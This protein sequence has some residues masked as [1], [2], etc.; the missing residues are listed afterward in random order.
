MKQVKQ[1]VKVLVFCAIVFGIC[2]I[3]NGILNTNVRSYDSTANP[4]ADGSKVIFLGTS[5]AAN[6]INPL[7]MWDEQGIAG[8]NFS[9][10][11]QYIGT[12]YY[13]LKDLYRYQTPEVIM[14]DF[15]CMTRPEDFLTI[16]NKLYNLPMIAGWKNRLDMYRDVIGDSP[17]YIIPMLRYH[18]RWKELSRLDFRQDYNVLG[19][20]RRLDTQ[21]ITEEMPGNWTIDRQVKLGERELAYLNRIYEMTEEHG[22]RLT[23][24][25]MP[26]YSSDEMESLTEQVRDWAKERG[27]AICEAN[28]EDAF[29]DMELMPE[30]FADLLHLNVSGQVKLSSYIGRWL[31]TECGLLDERDTE[32]GKLWEAKMP[33]YR[34]IFN[35]S[36]L[37]TTEDMEEYFELL[38][39]GNYTIAISLVGNYKSQDRDGRLWS[40]LRQFG[41]S[42]EAYDAGGGFVRDA[43]GNWIFTSGGASSFL[44]STVL[45][46]D[47]LVLRGSPSV[48]ADGN[49]TVRTEL[50]IYRSDQS[51][52]PNG[53]NVMVYNHEIDGVV[54]TVGFNADDEFRILRKTGE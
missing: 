44:W 46:E 11:G 3:A 12:T 2:L 6:G 21:E 43:Q 30:D 23:L 34:N 47:D 29:A 26:S 36:L 32:A 28:G 33:K 53:I 10:A 42:K 7:M 1:A 48:D 41:F 25:D 19:V 49:P 39:Q 27:V 13:L 40:T 14:L 8:Y 54:E 51:V 38:N 45:D 5:Q 50:I 18:N 35:D 16:S 17:V 22:T 4:E 52:L 20:G 31:K 24:I 37:L 9:G 15:E